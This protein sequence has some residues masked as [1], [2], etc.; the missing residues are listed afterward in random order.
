VKHE[1]KAHAQKHKERQASVDS[2]HSSHFIIFH[3]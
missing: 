2:L 1:L 3:Y